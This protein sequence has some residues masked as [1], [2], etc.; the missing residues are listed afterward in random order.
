[1]PK[2]IFTFLFL[3]LFFTNVRAQKDSV[4]Y[5]IKN[6][7]KLV[8]NKDSADYSV[9]ITPVDS[10]L[11][12]VK[13]YFKTGK[14]GLMGKSTNSTL[15]FNFHG[16]IVYYFPN[17]IKMYEKN[18]KNGKPVGDVIEYYPNGKFYN[19][20]HYE[21]A[22]GKSK[23]LLED[24]NDRYGNILAANGNGKW[25][26][27]S[28]NFSKLL[29]EGPVINGMEDGEWHA[30][31]ADSVD[32]IEIYKEGKIIKREDH[33]NESKIYTSVEKVPE[34]PGGINAFYDFIRKNL[35]YPLPAYNGGIQGEVDLSF[36]V[37]EDGSLTNI[38]VRRGI[39][40][41]CDEEAVR[42]IK[43]SPKW[44]PGIQNGKPIRI[45]YGVPITFS[46]K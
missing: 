26:K 39:G 4:I 9:V 36:V 3:T 19:R 38:E 10:N 5:Y 29:E 42:I 46:L 20:K 30:K 13:E 44:S 37:E 35:K 32:M 34:F 23:L 33:S 2:F 17:G 21:N 1:M 8:S 41:G 15:H 24:C 25:Q 11:F 18:F 7:D 16:L 45:G 40:G 14:L 28:W 31:M 22:E 12:L 6:P 27:Y 43:L